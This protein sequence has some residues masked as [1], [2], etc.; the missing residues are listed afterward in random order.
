MKSEFLSLELEWYVVLV[1]FGWLVSSCSS[2]SL[3]NMCERNCEKYQ[4]S[5][6]WI[7]FWWALKV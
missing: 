7:E 2:I 5:L 3:S 6:R 1:R 4:I